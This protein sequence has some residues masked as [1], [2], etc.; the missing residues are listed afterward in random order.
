MNRRSSPVRPSVPDDGASSRSDAEY[1]WAEPAACPPAP[2]AR[3]RPAPVLDVCR[4]KAPA[5]PPRTRTPTLAPANDDPAAEPTAG[6]P[7]GVEPPGAEPPPP[8]AGPFSSVAPR[9]AWL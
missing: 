3:V 2:A 7:P 9:I 1:I 4:A 6:D 8:L 5:E